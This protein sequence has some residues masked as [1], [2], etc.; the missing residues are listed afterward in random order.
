MKKSRY[1]LRALVNLLLGVGAIFFY[2]PYVLNA[3]N[4]KTEAWSKM[5]VKLLGDNY[6]N[7][8]IWFGL[9]LMGYIVIFN[10][11]TILS[12][13]N[14]AKLSF[15]LTS[16]VSLLLPIVYVGALKYNAILELWIKAFAPNVK[17][18]GLGFLVASFGLLFLGIFTSVKKHIKVNFYYLLQAIFMCALLTLLVSVNNWCGWD[19]NPTKA[20]GM[21]MS[22]MSV[23]LMASSIILFIFAKN[24]YRE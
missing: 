10:I 16:V 8:M 24:N 3:F 11:A 21:L 17:T 23:Y 14:G 2:T 13:A 20:F 19:V 1:G 6:F 4:I 12:K 5:L 22:I 18:I 9:V 7:I 15:K